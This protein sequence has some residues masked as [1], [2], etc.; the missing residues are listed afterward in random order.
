MT[1]K[2]FLTD[3]ESSVEWQNI[4]TTYFAKFP[5]FYVQGVKD[6]NG[7]LT[8]VSMPSLYDLFIDKY[9]IQEIGGETPDLFI[10]SVRD[11][12][13]ELVMKYLPKLAT[14]NQIL[15]SADSTTHQSQAL[16]N[17]FEMI[18]TDSYADCGYIYP[19][20]ATASKLSGKTTNE[21]TKTQK[22]PLGQ[23]SWAQLTKEILSLPDIYNQILNELGNC[24]MQIL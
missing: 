11:K 17:H 7:V 24:F 18:T 14:L 12:I 13:Q 22:I 20:N 16:M 3:Y 6:K 23:T 2:D 21:G 9:D 4:K 1:F 15:Y 5:D 8:D 19:I 10:H